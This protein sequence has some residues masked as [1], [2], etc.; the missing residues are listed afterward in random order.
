MLACLVDLHMRSKYRISLYYITQSACSVSR[1]YCS[2]ATHWQCFSS[3]TQCTHKSKSLLLTVTDHHNATLPQVSRDTC[4]CL[5]VLSVSE[6]VREELELAYTPEPYVGDSA[7]DNAAQ[8]AALTATINSLQLAQAVASLTTAGTASTA[9]TTA[10]EAE[11]ARHH[12]KLASLRVVFVKALRSRFMRLV[13]TAGT[14]NS[15]N[16]GSGSGSGTIV[17]EE[18]ITAA[19]GAEG[20]LFFVNTAGGMLLVARALLPPSISPAHVVGTAIAQM[21]HVPENA[22]SPLTALVAAAPADVPRVM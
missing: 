2:Y 13:V 6:V 14:N 21:L 18:D 1:M 8:A 9:A 16:S 17:S 22:V 11:A 5:K 19:N 10:A 20:S 12:A 7:A 15:S 4:R 3:Q